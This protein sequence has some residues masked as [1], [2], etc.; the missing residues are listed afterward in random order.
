MA[1]LK[2]SLAQIPKKPAQ[3]V[4][5]AQRASEVSTTSRKTA[6]KKGRVA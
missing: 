3:R 4:A 1:A 6:R 5:E 2:E